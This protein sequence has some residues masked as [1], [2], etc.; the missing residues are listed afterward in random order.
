MAVTD[1][2]QFLQNNEVNDRSLTVIDRSLRPLTVS[3]SLSQK[4]PGYFPD[5]AAL[6]Q[7]MNAHLNG[8]P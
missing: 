6:S 1:C 7:N 8:Q 5:P 2:N 3:L 4:L